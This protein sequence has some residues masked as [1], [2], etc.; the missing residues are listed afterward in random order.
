MQRLYLLCG[1]AFA[2]KTTLA[3]ELVRRYGM[4]VISPD[5]INRERGV[6]F[7]GDG[8][9][10]EVWSQTHEIGLQRLEELMQLKGPIVVDDTACYR[11]LRDDYRR[12]ARRR[13]Y[14]VQLIYLDVPLAEIA[15]RRQRNEAH[16]E[17]QPIAEEVFR[18][19]VA[20]FEPAAADEAAL[21]TTPENE[22]GDWIDQHRHL[23]EEGP[24]K[25]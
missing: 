3:R 11:W 4:A 7:G 2:G 25:L 22:L 12:V 9:P 15:R 14:Q 16:G 21:S 19:H 5:E 23:F 1:V 8:L 10:D 20:T 24:D 17:R 13:G 6:S 18:Q